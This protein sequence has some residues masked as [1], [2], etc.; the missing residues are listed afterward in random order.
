M[1]K[2]TRKSACGKAAA[3]AALVLVAA[4]PGTF[5]RVLSLREC[6]DIAVA[7]NPDMGVARQ[8]LHKTE[9]RVMQSYGNLL[10]GFT[11]DFYAGHRFYGP[12]SV[13]IDER[14]REV[15][16]E[17]FD[18]EDYTLRFGSDIVLWD[19]GGNYA[20]LRQARLG[21]AGAQEEFAYN[22]NLMTAAVIR[23][24]YNLVRGR[25]LLAVA[26]ES[27]EQARQSLE[28][29]EAL[30]EVGSATRADVLKASVRH[31]NTRLDLIRSTN[32]VELAREDLRAL[33]NRP[34]DGDID[35]DTTLVIDLA[36]ADA[37][38]EVAYALDNRSDLRSLKYY[39]ESAESGITAA[40]SGW[41]PT[42]GATFGYIWSDRS[43]ADNLNFFREEYQWNIH[44]F[45]R[46]N[47]FD[48]FRTSTEV[49]TARADMR[50]AEY[51]LERSRLGAVREV[52]SLVL[53]ID[54]AG[55]RIEV[56][57]ETVE[58]AREDVRL[59]EERY[60]V[61][62]GTMLDAITAQVALTQARA[63]V[64]DAKCDYLIAVADLARATGRE[65]APEPGN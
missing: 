7:N 58:Q 31:S 63:D 46:L 54:E 57:S 28:R 38:R 35:V 32:R 59:A 37:E 29:T 3:L 23:S 8:L 51:N 16:R 64:I 43:M 2:R 40:R 34:G 49:R 61:G 18:Y 6:I 19:G 65:V 15:K 9:S 14:G 53:M 41:L 21:R 62:A 12:S 55:Q 52:K 11:V 24:Y 33:L 36:L 1:I 10:P 5:A 47:V 44:A 20:R 48:R 13:L 42:L 50:I 26:A 25:M 45:V 60:R 4:A 30:L 56:A 39:V 22:S 17:G 27:V